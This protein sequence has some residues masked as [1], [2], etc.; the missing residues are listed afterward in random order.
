MTT[1]RILTLMVL[2]LWAAT[3]LAAGGQDI[4]IDQPGARHGQAVDL[5]VDR[6]TIEQEFL[7]RIGA[8]ECDIVGVLVAAGES[9]DPLTDEIVHAMADLAGLAII[10]EAGRDSLGQSEMLAIIRHQDATNLPGS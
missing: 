1:L 9:V 6:V 7:H 4:F 3:T 2:L 10:G 5:A 8:D